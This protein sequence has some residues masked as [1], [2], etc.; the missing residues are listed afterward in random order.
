[1]S[2]SKFAQKVKRYYDAGTWTERMVR[3]ALAKERI[4]ALECACILRDGVLEALGSNPTKAELLDAAE[5]LGLAVP[6][7]ATK[8]EIEGLIAEACA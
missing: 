5:M 2:Y 1:M 7:G 4:N 8:A 6:E 3:D